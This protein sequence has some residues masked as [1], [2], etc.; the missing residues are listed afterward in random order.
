MRPEA[1]QALQLA[2]FFTYTFAVPIGNPGWPFEI[3][4]DQKAFIPLTPG[5]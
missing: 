4:L 1:E 2:L 5:R 3:F